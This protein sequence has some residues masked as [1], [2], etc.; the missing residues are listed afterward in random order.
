MIAPAGRGGTLQYAHNLCNAL[1]DAGDEVLLATGLDCETAAFPRRY[2]LARVFDRFHPLPRRQLAFLR[3]VRAMRPDIVHFQGAQRPEF[4]RLM[5]WLV[6]ALGRPT[7][8][9]TP[10][11]V[12]S[13]SDRPW[14]RRIQTGNYRRMS[15]VFLN[16]RQNREALQSFFAVPEE[17]ITVLPMPDLVAFA[18]HDLDSTPPPELQ[19]DTGAPILLCF[20][21]IEP[22]K[23]I[24]QLIEAFAAVAA[25][26][27]TAQ[28]LIFG[29]PLSAVDPYRHALD[30]TGLAGTRAQIIDRYASFEEMNWLFRTAAAVILPYVSGWNSGVLASAFGYGC[31]VIATRVGGFDE[32]VEDGRTG[33]LVPPGDVTALAAAM[34]RVLGDPALAGSLAEGA[35]AAGRRASWS[36]VAAMTRAAYD[37]ASA[38]R[39]TH[40]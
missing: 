39:A 36:E 29:K 24:G 17:R 34:D 5:I 28:L 38:A 23:G 7:L 14:H 21:L 18:R 22:R 37:R 19:L 2:G 16:A 27:P 11:D 26:H 12:L 35:Q 1:A 3:H 4:Y 9:W 32:V 6:L 20:G 30:S 40:G 33:L 15:H 25:R 31:P 8:V 10:Q 13:N